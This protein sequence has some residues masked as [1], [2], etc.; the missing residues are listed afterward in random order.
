MARDVSVRTNHSSDTEVLTNVHV[1]LARDV[2]IAATKHP[3]T[4][5]FSDDG[6]LTM[7]GELSD[8]ATK[9]RA[10]KC[11]AAV[12]G[13]RWIVDHLAIARTGPNEDGALR[14]HL[15]SSLLDD[16]AFL[17]TRILVRTNSHAQ[18]VRAPDRTHGE[19]EITVQDGVV[20]LDGDVPSASHRRL[21]GVYAWWSPGTRN[22]HNGLGVTPPDTE[23]DG[24]IS[25]AIRLALEKDPLVNAA[26]LAVRTENGRVTI[27]GT[28]RTELEKEI[29][30][31]DVW[32]VLGV[33]DV[34]NR[35]AV[36]P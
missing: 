12:E 15:V 27:A 20:T 35:I 30:E 28:V 7:E 29:V 4:L 3:I 1:A 32:Y 25:D 22:V 2:R 9:K 23:D 26:Q 34:V 6:V 33:D 13:V 16:T 18:V 14:D 21:A 11:A 8:V 24:E 5:A 36:S 17:E 19:I 31:R 10:L